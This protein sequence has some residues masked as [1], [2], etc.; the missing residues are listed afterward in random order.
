MA[1]DFRTLRDVKAI[2]SRAS[3]LAKRKE[4]KRALDRERAEDNKETQVLDEFARYQ[5]GLTDDALRLQ[6]LHSLK[7]LLADLNAQAT[8]A[9]DSPERARARRV[10][11]VVTMG[12]A[13]YTQD[14]EYSRLL[15]QYRLPARGTYRSP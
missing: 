1:D 4:I 2:D 13:E 10:L 9:E 7:R 14:A 6:S 12:A 3:E 15:Q 5:A 8:A 11:R